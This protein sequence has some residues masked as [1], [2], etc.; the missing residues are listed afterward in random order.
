MR[1][2][3]FL[4]FWILVL[5][6][7]TV[8]LL[9]AQPAPVSYF[10]TS[11]APSA[12]NT[13]SVLRR[14]EGNG[15]FSTVGTVNE[16]G[17]GL[18]LNALGFN[19]ADAL[20]VYGMNM[21]YEGS[22]TPPTF[23]RVSLA[24]AAA[25]A[26][27]T[28]TPPTTPSTTFPNLGL[29]YVLAQLGDGGPNSTFYLAG[30]T[31]RYNLFTGLVSDV[32]FYVGTAN[33]AGASPTIPVWRQADI[34]DPAA[35]AIITDFIRRTNTSVTDGG[36]L[37]EGGIQDWV[38]DP[39]SGHLVSYLGIEQKFLTIS[40]PATAPRAVVTTPAV[41]LPVATQIGYMFRDGRNNL[42]GM[43]ADGGLV[44]H[45]DRLTGSYLG[46]FE[47][48]GLGATRGD[49]T[50]APG[51]A[52]PL[53]VVLT[54]F[55]ARPEP[56]R[57][58]LSWA[59]A[60]EAKTAAFEVQ[61]RAATGP[62]WAAIGSVTATNAASGSRYAFADTAPGAGA[63]YYRLAIR[64]LDGTV[65]YS[66]VQVATVSKALAVVGFDAYPNPC[67]GS[68]TLRLLAP[69]PAGSRAVLADGLGRPVWS[70]DLGGEQPPLAVRLPANLPA[71]VYTLRCAGATQRLTVE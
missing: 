60:S 29:S 42:F 11:A 32:R 24:T 21:S 1:Y 63:N 57:V 71:G 47:D 6:A 22:V 13:P 43:S 53:P 20:N 31:L 35:N 26:L 59:T 37:P 33:L 64:D 54:A 62:T 69:A 39:A 4:S 7:C 50:T 34:S 36:P 61:R 30:A 15:R 52:A 56:A 67:Q 18:T 44:Y 48:S 25:T 49:A 17:T 8:T 28:L 55:A 51:L 9:R 40:N 19:S 41:L 45:L 65:A 27:G 12:N 3:A 38:Y 23:Y 66:P 14:L 5:L 10:V 16:A 70:A 68:F 46:T 58:Q 2:L